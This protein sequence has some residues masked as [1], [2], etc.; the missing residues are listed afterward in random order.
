ML[1]K[2]EII[3][4]QIQLYELSF[5]VC[6]IGAIFFAVLTLYI[7][8]SLHIGKVISQLTGHYKSKEIV[9]IHQNN[10]VSGKIT[11]VYGSKKPLVYQYD[12]EKTEKLKQQEEET[13]PLAMDE[14]TQPLPNP[15]FRTTE[16]VVL[17]HSEEW[18]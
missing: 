17:G 12:E 10:M 16:T 4:N 6:L 18:I 1:E 9:R 5:K 3:K 7:Y 14:V 11:G 8:F 2:V 15:D 13:V